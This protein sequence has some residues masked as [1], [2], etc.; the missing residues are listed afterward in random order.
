MAKKVEIFLLFCSLILSKQ[1]QGDGYDRGVEPEDGH[2]P[3]G[4]H[5]GGLH[6]G[7]LDPGSV[8]LLTVWLK[9]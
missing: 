8:F 1:K 4:L 7:G 2:D 6:P 3:G 5:P 9:L